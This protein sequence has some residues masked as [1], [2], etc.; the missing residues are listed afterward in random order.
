MGVEG[1]GRVGRRPEEWL[2]R[3]HPNVEVSISVP[4]I[5]PHVGNF[6]YVKEVSDP[7]M[8]QIMTH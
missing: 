2:Q 4:R 3:K 7:D 8:V 5:R 6:D 1:K